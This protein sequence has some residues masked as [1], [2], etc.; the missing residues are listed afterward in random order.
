MADAATFSNTQRDQDRQ[1][2]AKEELMRVHEG[3]TTKQIAYMNMLEKDQLSSLDPTDP[4]AMDKKKLKEASLYRGK[5]KDAKYMAAISAESSRQLLGLAAQENHFAKA[6]LLMEEA[7]AMNI[8]ATD[9][10]MQFRDLT[11]FFVARPLSWIRSNF[12]GI[13]MLKRKQEISMPHYFLHG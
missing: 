6:L 13:R 7:N 1:E 2:R 5:H 10:E 8:P 12:A 9:V 3:L 11:N 4:E